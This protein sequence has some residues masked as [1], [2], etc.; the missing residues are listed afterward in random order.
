MPSVYYAVTATLPDLSTRD[1]FVHWLRTGHVQ[2]VLRGGAT[3]AEIIVMD[4]DGG[5]LAVKAAYAF[6]DRATFER[7]LSEHA[8][9]LRAEGIAKFGSRP[10]VSFIRELGSH[11]EF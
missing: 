11:I 6:P 1:E 7:Y 5:S 10:G 2:D 4:V 9:R 8:P 3:R